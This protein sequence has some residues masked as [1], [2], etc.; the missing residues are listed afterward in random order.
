MQLAQ[1]RVCLLLSLLV[2]V[3]L[4]TISLSANA[5]PIEG[6]EEEQQQQDQS[7]L[8]SISIE[9]LTDDDAQLS[10]FQE[11]LGIANIN[12]RPAGG[13][14][15]QIETTTTTTTTSE[16][17][18]IDAASERRHHFDEEDKKLIETKWNQMDSKIEERVKDWECP[19]CLSKVEP[20]DSIDG[21]VITSCCL[22]HFHANCLRRWFETQQQNLRLYSCPLCRAP[23]NLDDGSDDDN[24]E[25]NL[26]S[27]TTT[28]TT[29][30][31][32]T[33]RSYPIC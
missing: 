24:E 8:A 18:K 3:V 15:Q 13:N 30:S 17:N 32:T 20:N 9:Q 31:T 28:T 6:Q 4:L 29:M 10:R 5:R 23:V 12:Q 21:A 7:T 16:N 1:V 22:S 14:E 19:I 25:Q 27:I 26:D 11:S 2:S 33:H